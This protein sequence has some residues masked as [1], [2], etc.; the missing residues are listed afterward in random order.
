[1]G[2]SS[3]VSAATASAM[4]SASAISRYSIDG[5]HSVR[6][7][8]SR[9]RSV[10]PTAMVMSRAPPISYIERVVTTA[11]SGRPA[12]SASYHWARS[13]PSGLRRAGSGKSGEPA[14]TSPLAP[15]TLRN[16]R[17]CSG[18]TNRLSADGGTLARTSSSSQIRRSDS[19]LAEDSRSWSCT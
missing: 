11:R 4:A 9:L 8:W 18:E 10:L 17:S 2:R 12:N 15:V 19:T 7:M 3:S 14:S 1:M 5:H 13:T 6:S 16:T